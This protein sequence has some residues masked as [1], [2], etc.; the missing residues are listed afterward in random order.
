[1][2]LRPAGAGVGGAAA[3]DGGGLEMG[4]N[5]L[6]TGG[7]EQGMEGIVLPLPVGDLRGALGIG[8]EPGFDRVAVGRRQPAVDIG[9]QIGLGDLFLPLAHLTVLSR[10]SSAAPVSCRR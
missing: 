2:K 10:G 4:G 8:S 1:S 5:R 3:G 6:V 9:E 7:I